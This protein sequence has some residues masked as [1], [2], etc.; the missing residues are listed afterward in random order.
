[1]V[2]VLREGRGKEASQEKSRKQPHMSEVHFGFFFMG[3]EGELG[4]NIPIVAA[5]ERATGMVMAAVV[6]T[7]TTGGCIARRMVAFL[8]EV[9]LEFG[10]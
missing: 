3:K 6:P 1:M 5:K 10:D 7:K 4:R 8:Q 2:Q 9:C